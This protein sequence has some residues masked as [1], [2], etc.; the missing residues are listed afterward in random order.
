MSTLSWPRT[1]FERGVDLGPLHHAA[2]QRRGQRR[3]AQRAVL[4][5]LHERA[6]EAEQQHRAEL[7][8][9]AAAEDELVAVAVDHGLDGDALEVGGAVLL[10]DVRLDAA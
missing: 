2:C 3:Q 8:I 1:P 6:A 9:D 5:D 4:E 7:R 10:G